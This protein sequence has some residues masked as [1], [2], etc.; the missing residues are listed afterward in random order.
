MRKAGDAGVY[1]RHPA[2]VRESL[3]KMDTLRCRHIWKIVRKSI[4]LSSTSTSVFSKTELPENL[5][6]VYVGSPFQT[7]FHRHPEAGLPVLER[8]SYRA[9]IV[10]QLRCENFWMPKNTK[11]LNISFGETS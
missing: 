2:K 8:K 10:V 1:L 7:P 6:K 4:F 3:G 11:I 9:P 5:G